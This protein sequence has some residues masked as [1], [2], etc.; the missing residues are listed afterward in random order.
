MRTFHV[1]ALTFIISLN[2]L[3]DNETGATI[4]SF[5]IARRRQRADKEILRVLLE[6]GRSEVQVTEGAKNTYQ[7]S[8]DN[9]LTGKRR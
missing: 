6:R 3:L 2:A 8:G 7:Y 5:Q 9:Y 4:F 1:S